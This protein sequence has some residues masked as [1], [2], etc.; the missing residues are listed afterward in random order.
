MTS[1][2]RRGTMPAWVLPAL[3][4]GIVALTLAALSLHVPG[5]IWV[6]TLARKDAVVALMLASGVL[7]FVAVALLPRCHYG[8][9]LLW[10]VLAVSAALRVALLCAPP[11]MSSDIYRYVWDGRVQAAGHNPYRYIAADPALAALRDTSIYP[12]INRVDYAHTIYPPAAQLIFAA[13]GHISQTVT[14]MKIAM[15]VLETCGVAAMIAMLRRA[16]RPAAHILIYAW[17]P[18][19]AWAVAG[20]GHIDAAAIGFLGLA[21]WA[22]TARRDGLAGALL[23]G[24]ILSKLIPLAVA[25]ALW[26]RYNW[27]LPAVCASCIVLL[28]AVYAGVGW[29]VLGFLPTY[30]TEEGLVAGSGFWLLGALGHLVT[31]PQWTPQLYVSAALAGLAALAFW[32]GFMQKADAARDPAL[33]ARNVSLLAASTI[34]ALS[35]HYTWYYAWLALP[36]CVVPWP[37]LIW[38]ATAPILLYSDPWH[39]EI[40]LPTAVF[41]PFL[42]LATRD[43][44]RLRAAPEPLFAGASTS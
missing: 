15:V 5:S 18:L 30:T 8:G 36:A 17:N 21:M 39:D 20:D 40:L 19:A 32:I 33:L 7:Y 29:R 43:L 24:A 2:G 1:A 35:P 38:L 4:G 6:G 42:C 11:F 22:M 25:P 44:M 12:R 13:V 34:F 23:S 10:Q 16:G 41:V 28:Y 37:S 14:A 26:R 3:G 9:R 27:R 31:L